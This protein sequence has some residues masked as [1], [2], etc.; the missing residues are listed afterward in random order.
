MNGSIIKVER[1]P[2]SK[3]KTEKVT[4]KHKFLTNIMESPLENTLIK[5][6][7]LSQEIEIDDRPQPKNVHLEVSKRF[8]I[9]NLDNSNKDLFQDEIKGD[10]FKKAAMA[11]TPMSS[12]RSSKSRVLA[13]QKEIVSKIIDARLEDLK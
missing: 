5:K 10:K 7:E 6:R 12:L 13:K 1:L 11:I 8:P 9:S 2:I 3:Q 4:E